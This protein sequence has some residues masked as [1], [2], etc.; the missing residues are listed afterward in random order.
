MKFLG[1][2]AIFLAAVGIAVPDDASAR[3]RS[4]GRSFSHSGH[5]HSGARARVFIAAPLFV[6]PAF[7]PRPYY[8][9][10]APVYYAPP[11]V[12]MEQ[13]PSA[14]Q[15]YWYYCLAAGAYYPY[16]ADCPGGWQRVVPHPNSPQP[17]G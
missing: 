5:S 9:A 11:P 13:Y 10:P 17:A 12:Y 4:G 15:S 1:T 14:P 7:Y 16:V 3:G 6:A 8:Y 2:I